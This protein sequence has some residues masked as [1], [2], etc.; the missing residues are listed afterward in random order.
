MTTKSPAVTSSTANAIGRAVGEAIAE[1][2]AWKARQN[3]LMSLAAMTAQV[4]TAVTVIYAGVLPVWSV[5]II[6]A[7]IGV[8]ETLGHRLTTGSITPSMAP[9]L[10]EA[11]ERVTTTPSLPSTAEFAS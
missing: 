5:P 8:C 11:A 2:P 1:Q 10:E 4:L 6:A 3:S 7:V 9:R